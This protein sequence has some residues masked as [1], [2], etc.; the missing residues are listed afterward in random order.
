MVHFTEVAIK[1]IATGRLSKKLG[2]SLM[3]EIV[4]LQ[5][6][7]HLNIIRDYRGVQ[8]SDYTVPVE[9][10]AAGFQICAEELGSI[11]EGHDIKKFKFHGGIDGIAK[12]LSTSTTSVLTT[13]S[14][15]MDRKQEIFGINKFAESESRSF[16]IFVWEAL[17][18]MTLMI[19]AACAFVSLIVGI[20]MEGWPHGAMMVYW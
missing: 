6:M 2:E 12:K 16:W 19:L 15:L 1:E 5:K 8:P 14:E 7:K 17:Q 9:I 20:A 13:A 3:S 11:V 18:D 10:K 4:I